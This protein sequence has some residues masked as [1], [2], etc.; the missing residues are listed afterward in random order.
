MTKNSPA[1]ERIAYAKRALEAAEFV[2]EAADWAHRLILDECRQNTCQWV[3]PPGAGYGAP[4]SVVPKGLGA[5][6]HRSGPL[7]GCVFHPCETMQT[8]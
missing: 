1:G 7:V 5:T 4:A 6:R 8:P 2:D 3:L